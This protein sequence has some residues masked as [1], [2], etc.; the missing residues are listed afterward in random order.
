MYNVPTKMEVS[1]IILSEWFI[2]IALRY[3]KLEQENQLKSHFYCI[4]KRKNQVLTLLNSK[5]FMTGSPPNIKAVT[6]ISADFP[7]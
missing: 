7:L 4:C 6:I 1:S 3:K 2:I 5:R